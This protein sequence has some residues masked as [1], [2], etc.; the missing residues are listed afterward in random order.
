M[1]PHSTSSCG[2]YVV[3]WWVHNLLQSSNSMIRPS[4]EVVDYGLKHTSECF[5]FL[6]CVYS[7]FLLFVCVQRWKIKAENPF[8][9]MNRIL[10]MENRILFQ[11]SS[12]ENVIIIMIICRFVNFVNIK[13]TIDRTAVHKT[14]ITSRHCILFVVLSMEYVICNVITNRIIRLCKCA[15]EQN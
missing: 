6:W 4:G 11:L 1:I 5:M 9:N 12:T 10:V 7:S 8:I 13:E 2:S 15:H 14:H 3:G